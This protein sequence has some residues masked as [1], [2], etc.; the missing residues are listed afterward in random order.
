[1]QEAGAATGQNFF[2]RMRLVVVNDSKPVLIHLNEL[3]HKFNSGEVQNTTLFF[4]NLV[5]TMDE[6]RNSWMVPL[7]ESWPRNFITSVA[8][9]T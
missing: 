3:D 5:T 8:P 4:N 7:G 6:F 1:M 9:G 2:D